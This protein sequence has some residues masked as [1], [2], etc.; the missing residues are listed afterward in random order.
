M[1]LVENFYGPCLVAILQ[2][3]TLA[4]GVIGRTCT[5]KE[6]EKRQRLRLWYFSVGKRADRKNLPHC[7]CSRRVRR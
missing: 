7:S 5:K 6:E 3:C 1:L 2:P 4:S